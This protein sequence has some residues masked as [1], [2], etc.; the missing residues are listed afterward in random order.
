MAQEVPS[1]M[2][3]SRRQWL[4][5]TSTMPL[6]FLNKA[7]GQ[8]WKNP[9]N[10][11]LILASD[12]PAWILGAYGNQEI[13]TPNLDLLARAGTRFE[14]CYC[15]SPAS[16]PA[17]ASLLSGLTPRQHGILDTL[18]SPAEATNGFGQTSVPAKFEEI[19]LL[20]DF[21]A[22]N[23][24]VCGFVG[25][26]H[27]GDDSRP[28]GSF[29]FWYSLVD[30]K[31]DYT[32]PTVSDHGKIRHEQGYAPE[33]LTHKASEFL[34][35]HRRE[36]F[37]LLLSYPN[38][39][40]PYD[41][42]PAKYY[43]LYKDRDFL[44]FGPVPDRSNPSQGQEFLN[45]L[46]NS[47]RQY[48]AGVSALDDQVGMILQTLDHLQIRERTVV[49]FTAA[50]GNLVGRHRLWGDGHATSPPNMY[51]EVVRVP[52]LWHWFGVTPVEHVRPELVSHLDLLPAICNLTRTTYLRGQAYPGRPYEHLALRLD[53]PEREGWVNLVFS[54]LR[55]TEMVRDR[56][57]KLV[58]RNA[59]EGP[60][61]LYNLVDDPNEV[62][63]LY[64]NTRYITVW[65]AL[66][67][68][69]SNWRRNYS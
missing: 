29:K 9:P 28:R 17:R 34:K 30:P 16:S 50:C 48:A 57:F 61:E 13:H 56:R 37:F 25:K 44:S 14:F 47:R 60:N 45:D 15:A 35:L 18:V 65:Q 54:Q 26:W 1:N 64:G 42:H 21:L 46:T 59:G 52:L 51:E 27:L 33:L 2:K 23:S 20:P 39:Q 55:D 38:P 8:I 19:K 53:L 62:E 31:G 24:Y 6:A 4:S 68:E 7:T 67:R 69:L 58:V 41:Q 22:E 40:P 10:I 63:N 12:L 11:L 32:D 3:L 66:E 5:L 36:R 49:I 43:S